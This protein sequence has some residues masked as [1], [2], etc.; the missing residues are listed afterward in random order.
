MYWF[1]EP[2]K[3]VVVRMPPAFRALTAT[4][5]TFVFWNKQVNGLCEIVMSGN[6]N[7]TDGL[8]ATETILIAMK[9]LLDS[10]SN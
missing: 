1:T 10:N 8:E 2:E 6:R 4:P 7:L 5:Y 3:R 9:S